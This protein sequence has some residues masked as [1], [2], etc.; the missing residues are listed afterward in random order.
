MNY[1]IVLFLEKSSLGVTCWNF[2][3][4]GEGIGIANVIL[5]L[6]VDSGPFVQ[7]TCCREQ[8]REVEKVRWHYNSVGIDSRINH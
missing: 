5:F 2:P 1:K 4:G 7:F 6:E 8:S 3:G